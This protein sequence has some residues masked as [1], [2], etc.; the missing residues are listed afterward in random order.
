MAFIRNKDNTF[1]FSNEYNLFST[2]NWYN[3]I[4]SQYNVFPDI[5][6]VFPSQSMKNIFF[7]Y[8][9]YEELLKDPKYWKQ[10]GEE[11][12]GIE[13]SFK[14]TNCMTK[15][16]KSKEGETKKELLNE[17]NESQTLD[18]FT[19]AFGEDFTIPENWDSIHE[20]LSEEW[21]VK[22]VIECENE[23]G[24]S[25]NIEHD[26]TQVFLIDRSAIYNPEILKDINNDFCILIIHD[27]EYYN[28][29]ILYNVKSKVEQQILNHLVGIY[30]YCIL[31][32]KAKE[33]ASVS[34]IIETQAGYDT[35]NIEIVDVIKSKEN[36]LMHTNDDFEDVHKKSLEFLESKESGLII[37]RGEP[38]SGKTSYIKYLT[39]LF[40]KK[41]F[42]FVSADIMGDLGHP[43]FISFLTDNKNS[44]I[45]LEDCE[46]LL[47][48]RDNSL[49]SMYINEGLINLL[50]M[51]DGILG[52]AFNFK[53][54][55]TFNSK[56]ISKLDNALLR[57]GRC[58]VNYEFQKLSIDKIEKLIES[59]KIQNPWKDGKKKK[60]CV[61]ELYNTE[62]DN[63]QNEEKRKVGFC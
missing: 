18:D 55:C 19:Y 20:A 37:Y 63:Y 17:S 2:K 13:T 48:S 61:A 45:I 15:Y 50:N 28:P 35:K 56:N 44:I 14:L 6:K 43:N 46:Q 31:K 1:L 62:D 60:M 4:I 53:F 34:F 59:K 54:I 51:T 21:N 26:K 36:L 12:K 38:G 9:K 52:S 29:F 49:D 58:K 7:D 27:G 16:F 32:K 33:V 57:K 10:L 25:V 39:T 5:L 24:E 42:L 30:K 41:Q 3:F 8:K 22:N 11:F 40:P 23:D 47:V